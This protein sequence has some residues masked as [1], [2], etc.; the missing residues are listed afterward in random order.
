MKKKE[1]K[2][3]LRVR[4]SETDA[5][6]IVYYANF[7][8]W[9][10]VARGELFEELGVDMETW[11]NAEVMPVVVEAHCRYL[12]SARYGDRV[13]VET[14]VR[15]FGSKMME[16]NYRLMHEKN[17]QL[18]AEGYTKHV[19]VGKNGNPVNTPV[20]VKKLFRGHA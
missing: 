17:K 2:T 19:F 10:E 4:F 20:F 9:F 6:G 8:V 18:I 16:F 15:L 3:K 14:Q 12:R 13:S 1:F 11:R 7:L 5:W